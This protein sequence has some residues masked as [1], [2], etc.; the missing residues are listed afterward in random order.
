MNENDWIC[1]WTTQRMKILSK[2]EI[3]KENL[4]KERVIY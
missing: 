1:Q 2:Y 4:N 3:L